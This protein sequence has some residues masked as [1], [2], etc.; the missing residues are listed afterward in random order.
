MTAGHMTFLMEVLGD[1]T[2][3]YFQW[4]DTSFNLPIVEVGNDVPNIVWGVLL[5]I[6]VAWVEYVSG[7][8]AES[9]VVSVTCVNALKWVVDGFRIWKSIS[10]YFDMWA[11]HSIDSDVFPPAT[12]IENIQTEK[13]RIGGGYL[14]IAWKILCRL[15]FPQNRHSTV[16]IKLFNSF[17]TTVK[18]FLQEISFCQAL[19][20]RHS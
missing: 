20:T 15:I 4:N 10:L 14:R 7:V 3:Q 6:D 5:L 12:T 8:W 1:L 16:R 13:A 18:V 19:L 2:W 17:L 9:F 11:W